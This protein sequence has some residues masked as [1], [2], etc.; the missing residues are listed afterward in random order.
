[1]AFFSYAF[2]WDA[3]LHAWKVTAALKPMIVNLD[4][5]KGGKTIF[6][7]VN[8]AGYIGAL[9]GYKP[10]SLDLYLHFILLIQKKTLLKAGNIMYS[11]DCFNDPYHVSFSN[12]YIIILY[13]TGCLFPDNK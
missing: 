13:C 6:R 10:V 5:K 3:K 1:M 4:F 11:G 2:R 12:L 8:F 7:T 9:T